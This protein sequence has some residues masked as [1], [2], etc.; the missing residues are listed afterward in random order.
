MPLAAREGL[1]QQ[2]VAVGQDG[3]EPLEPQPFLDRIRQVAPAGGVGQHRADPV[4]EM[5]RER[6]FAPGIGGDL[7]IALAALR[8]VDPGL[9]D[10]E[11]LQ[12]LAGEQEGVAGDQGLDEV[13]LDLA[14]DL[15]P[16]KPDLQRHRLDDGADIHPVLARHDGAGDA[17]E[18]VF[19]VPDQPLEAVVAAERVTA[20]RDEVQRVVEILAGERSA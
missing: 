2:I 10:A 7:G 3:A 9:R 1:D 16:A 14:Q 18:A 12:Q 19:L 15:A 11:E 17:V 8:A 6:H 20:G 4:G 5:G 13:L